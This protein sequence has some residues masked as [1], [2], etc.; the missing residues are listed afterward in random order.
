MMA[1]AA[2]EGFN[3]NGFYAG[4]EWGLDGWSSHDKFI[5]IITHMDAAAKAT[6]NLEQCSQLAAALIEHIKEVNDASKENIS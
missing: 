3:E 6:L 1:E 5:M 4:L 2:F